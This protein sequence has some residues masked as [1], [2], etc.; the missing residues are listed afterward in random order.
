MHGTGS[1]DDGAFAEDRFDSESHGAL[2]DRIGIALFV[3]SPDAPQPECNRRA[4]KLC[5]QGSF[6]R[7]NDNQ[8]VDYTDVRTWQAAADETQPL[9]LCF[10]DADARRRLMLCHVVRFAGQLIVALRE[11]DEGDLDPWLAVDPLTCACPHL[12]FATR[13]EN[14]IQRHR[15]YGTTFSV[16]AIE[17]DDFAQLAQ[18]TGVSGGIPLLARLGRLFVATLREIDI[19]TH[20]RDGEFHVVLPNVGLG[21]AHAGLER[22]R[23]IVESQSFTDLDQ[24]MTLSGGIVEYAGETAAALFERCSLQLAQA[25]VRPSRGFCVDFE[26]L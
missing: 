3:F 8:T 15:R 13:L 12:H 24:R 19:V 7:P 5:A 11:S 20:H 23:A 14:E 6:S 2:L 9:Q 18:R 25:R 16:A 21:E 1:K 4:A 10:S 17:I 22:L 26:L